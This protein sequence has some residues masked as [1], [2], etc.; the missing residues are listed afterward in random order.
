MRPALTDDDSLDRC[1]TLRAGLPG[2]LVCTEIVLKITAAVDPIDAGPISADA[3]LQGGTDAMPQRLGLLRGN[4]LRGGEGVQAGA[5]QA[6][7]HIDVA[8]PSQKGLIEQQGFQLPAVCLQTPVQVSWGESFVKRLRA[9][10]A[11]HAG[12]I[13]HQPGAPELAWIV[14]SQAAAVIQ[15]YDQPVVEG[16]LAIIWLDSQITAHAQVNEQI[17]RSKVQDQK[18][19]APPGTADGLPGDALLEFI[20][21]RCLE[22]ARPQKTNRSNLPSRQGGTQAAGNGFNFGQLWHIPFTGSLKFLHIPNA[23]HSSIQNQHIGRF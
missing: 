1:S 17:I 8:Q 3:F 21:G 20:G 5:V 6:F 23:A 19:P 12:L 18:L 14:E 22:G 9:K 2:A 10:T 4:R 7:I 11:N 15:R 16:I 13:L